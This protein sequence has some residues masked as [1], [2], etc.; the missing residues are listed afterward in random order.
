MLKSAKFRNLTALGLAIA[1]LILLAASLPRLE[2]APGRD[3]PLGAILAALRRMGG[4]LPGLGPL[5]F[6]P[7]RLLAALLWL[8]LIVAVLMFIFSPQARREILK[9]FIIYLVWALLI[10]GLVAVFQPLAWPAPASD[11]S[12]ATGELVDE[13]PPE[14][15]IPPPPEFVFNPP[16]WLVL[17]TTVLL[18][19]GPLAAGWWLWRKLQPPPPDDSLAELTR[20]AQ[21]AAAELAAGQD[22]K[23]TV[24]RCYR[25][26]SLTLARS[27]NLHRASGMTPREFEA[28]L[29]RSG[30]R[31]EHIHRLT[32]L[33]ERVR[34]GGQS[35]GRREELDAL[36]CFNAIANTYGRPV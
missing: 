31:T 36:D 11:D 16:Q 3:L 21:T 33:F 28:H 4:P 24:L 27:R 20:S 35:L 30:L 12:P 8:A 1:A 2:L 6:D 13:A 26:M 10:Y 22:L 18:L 9:R 17:A 14:E 29:A 23:D 34:Y 15:I 7:F 32:E 25:D 5:P 19:A